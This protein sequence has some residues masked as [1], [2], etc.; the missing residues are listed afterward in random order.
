MTCHIITCA[1]PASLDGQSI[2]DSWGYRQRIYCAAGHSRW[3]P[4]PRAEEFDREILA[5]RAPGPRRNERHVGVPAMTPVSEASFVWRAASGRTRQP[6]T[7]ACGATTRH[8]GREGWEWRWCR[9][10]EQEITGPGRRSE[11][12]CPVCAESQ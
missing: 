1:A 2:Q 10:D 9:R 7:C 4:G 6:W 11:T 12:R 8:P 5:L 3:E